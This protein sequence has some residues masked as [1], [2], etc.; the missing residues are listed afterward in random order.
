MEE[1]FLTEHERAEHYRALYQSRGTLMIF[2]FIAGM[3][4]GYGLGKWW[5]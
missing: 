3:L 2:L 1:H 4:I 5:H